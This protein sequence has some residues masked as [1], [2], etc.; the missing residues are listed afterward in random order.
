MHKRALSSAPNVAGLGNSGRALRQNS[1]FTRQ[2]VSRSYH[3]ARVYNAAP[4]PGKVTLLDYGAG[5]VRSVVNA[6]KNLGCDVKMVSL[7]R[8]QCEN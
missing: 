4:A 6:L 5:N 3:R 2:R 7:T 1:S 8:L